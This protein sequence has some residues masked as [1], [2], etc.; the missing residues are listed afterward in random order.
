MFT[1]AKVIEAQDLFKRD[2]TVQSLIPIIIDDHIHT[3]WPAAM[4]SEQIAADLT[5]QT[6]LANI[7]GFMSIDIPETR[8]CSQRSE[9]R[10]RSRCQ[11]YRRQ[12][13][14]HRL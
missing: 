13:K 6:L 4:P 7:V 9:E 2:D 14:I 10:L 1:N 11:I 3:P 8:R 5:I 12:F